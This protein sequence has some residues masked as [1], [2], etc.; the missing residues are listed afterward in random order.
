MCEQPPKHGD[1]LIILLIASY[2]LTL[3]EQKHSSIETRAQTTTVC[4][5]NIA[6][7]QTRNEN[8]FLNAF[9]SSVRLETSG[10]RKENK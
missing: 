10:N 4:R 9:T 2:C 3:Y 8:V 5:T 7:V 1:V 6:V